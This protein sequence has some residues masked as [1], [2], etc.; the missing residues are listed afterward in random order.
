MPVNNITD[1]AW[2]SSQAL[3]FNIMSYSLYLKRFDRQ[4]CVTLREVRHEDQAYIG[5]CDNHGYGC[6]TEDEK[7]V[8]GRYAF[9]K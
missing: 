6:V 8:Y 3:S 1:K 2:D 4:C 5:I 9:R 7:L